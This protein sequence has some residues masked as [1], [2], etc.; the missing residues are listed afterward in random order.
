MLNDKV[1]SRQG[2]IKSN[3]KPIFQKDC[4]FELWYSFDIWN[5]MPVHKLDYFVIPAE[6]PPLA[7]LTS[8]DSRFSPR[9]RAS[10]AGH[11]NDGKA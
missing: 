11:G 5:L 9:W 4:D 2:G 1:Q 7:G 3:S 8:L 10:A 6:V